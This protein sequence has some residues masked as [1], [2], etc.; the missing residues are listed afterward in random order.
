MNLAVE[1]GFS[2]LPAAW[3]WA[4]YYTVVVLLILCLKSM[5]EQGESNVLMAFGPAVMD[6]LRI[7]GTSSQKPLVALNKALGE[8]D[9][10]DSF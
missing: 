7:A 1:L 10:L 8:H 2:F 5:G 6:C 3:A 9:C 4:G